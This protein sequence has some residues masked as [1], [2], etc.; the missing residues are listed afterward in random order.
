MPGARKSVPT[1]SR[2]WDLGT[3]ARSS[4]CQQVSVLYPHYQA[5]SS[6]PQDSLA[7]NVKTQSGCCNRETVL[8]DLKGQ[9]SKYEIIII[10]TTAYTES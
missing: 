7:Q 4:H 8:S 5:V 10:T 2:N 9:T 6:I 3:T 1:I